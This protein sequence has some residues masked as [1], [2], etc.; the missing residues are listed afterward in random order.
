LS[1][2]DGCKNQRDSDS[3]GDARKTTLSVCT[4]IQ[5]HHTL[6]C[7]DEELLVGQNVDVREEVAFQGVDEELARN[8]RAVVS[9]DI[10]GRV[11]LVAWFVDVGV[12]DEPGLLCW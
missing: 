6:V 5:G 1:N 11:E 7:D 2:Q 12:V 4:P 8:R 10:L 3:V 9:V